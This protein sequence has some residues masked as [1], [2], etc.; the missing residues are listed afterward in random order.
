MRSLPWLNDETQDPSSG[1]PLKRKRKHKSDQRESQQTSEAGDADRPD[2][3]ST[4]TATVASSHSD[5]AFD[6]MVTGYEHDDAY[7]M[8]EHDLIEA[9]KR[10]TKQLH[11]EAY[12]R[13][14]AAPVVGDITR[15][16]TELSR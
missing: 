8:V 7:I 14:A 11:L 2:S 4:E 3:D 13:H 9:A 10:V 12:L 5:R 1:N 6:A 15:P 16:T